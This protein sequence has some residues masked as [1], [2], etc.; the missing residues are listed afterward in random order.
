MRKRK[1]ERFPHKTPLLIAHQN[2]GAFSAADHIILRD[3]RGQ[4]CRPS[5]VRDRAEPM[6]LRARDSFLVRYEYVVPKDQGVRFVEV[7]DDENEI[8]RTNNIVSGALTASKMLLPLEVLFPSLRINDAKVKF[9]GWSLYGQRTVSTFLVR[10]VD[11][12]NVRVEVRAY[13]N[14][15]PIALAFINCVAQPKPIEPPVIKDKKVNKE[16]LDTVK[17]YFESL[18]IESHAY[19]DRG[20]AGDY[21]YPLAYIA[22][23]PSGEIVKQLKGQGG[24]LNILRM[25]FKKRQKIPIVGRKGPE[26]RIDRPRIRD[27]FNRIITHIIDGV[28][29]YYRGSAIVHPESGAT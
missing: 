2:L 22:S 13:Q 24:T 8:H 1:S 6:T 29:T 28:I 9:V 21:T 5:I 18:G 10:Y 4:S 14:Q 25:D 20:P 3:P 12:C 23:L 26:V 16:H 11:A 19:F 17:A 7:T 15:S 27:R